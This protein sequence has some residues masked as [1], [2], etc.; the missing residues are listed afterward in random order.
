M[1]N[2]TNTITQILPPNKVN[3]LVSQTKGT[4]QERQRCM[5]IGLDVSV[6]QSTIKNNLDILNNHRDA[7]KSLL[8]AMELDVRY[9]EEQV[10]MEEDK[11]IQVTKS[12]ES[13][14]LLCHPS[15]QASIEPV[16]HENQPDLGLKHTE[17]VKFKSHQDSEASTII[18]MEQEAN[19]LYSHL[20]NSQILELQQRTFEDQDRNLVLL[21]QSVGRQRELGYL[22]GDEL[23]RHVGLL[24]ET[25]AAINATDAHLTRAHSRLKRLAHHNRRHQLCGIILGLILA[26]FVLIGI[27][28]LF[29]L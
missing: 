9:S 14:E 18:A 19:S 29:H 21:S 4:I 13:L 3:K 22:I 26:L 11:W 28:R 6:H 12:I 27:I 17:T 1:E 24:D 15:S 5:A 20:G 16:A 8:T 25:D 10:R 23:D 2:N 7:L